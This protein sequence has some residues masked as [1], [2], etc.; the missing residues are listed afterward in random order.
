M[1]RLTVGERFVCVL[2]A[3]GSYAVTFDDEPLTNVECVFVDGVGFAAFGDEPYRW[4]YVRF[5]EYPP[6]TPPPKPVILDH[7]RLY[8]CEVEVV[9]LTA[10]SA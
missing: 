5:V 10:W 6:I 8:G 2:H 3:D 7:L 9:D 4:R 1:T